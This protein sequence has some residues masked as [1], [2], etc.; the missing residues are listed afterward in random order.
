MNNQ[1]KYILRKVHEKYFP[2]WISKQKKKG[3]SI[4]LDKWLRT[5]MKELVQSTLLGDG[6]INSNLFQYNSVKRIVDEHIQGKSHGHR[7]WALLCY[8]LWENNIYSS[9]ID[10]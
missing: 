10:L 9:P 2:K 7:I 6:L 3:F 8:Q 4:P 1:P 5:D